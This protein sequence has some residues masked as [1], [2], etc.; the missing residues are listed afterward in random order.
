MKPLVRELEIVLNGYC[1]ENES[2][3]PDFILAKFMLACLENFNVATRERDRWY[4]VHLEPGNKYFKKGGASMDRDITQSELNEMATNMKDV[5]DGYDDAMAAIRARGLAAEVV[6]PQEAIDYLADKVATLQREVQECER[7]RDEL[8][9]D[10]EDVR[11]Q[12]TGYKDQHRR[13]REY[14]SRLQRAVGIS[15]GEAL[16]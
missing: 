1:E 16:R 10:L 7:E 8:S 13:D 9:K 4:G 5:A 6:S 3:T 15:K 2:N 14:I 11:K 12:L